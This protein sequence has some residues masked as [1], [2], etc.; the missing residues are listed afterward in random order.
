MELK[1]YYARLRERHAR[2]DW[3]SPESIR[4]YNEYA[5]KLRKQME[6]EQECKESAAE[7]L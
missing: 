6:H 7:N 3:G 5:K 1:E 4:A 2:T